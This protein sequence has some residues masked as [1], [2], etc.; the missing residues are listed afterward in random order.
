MCP[1]KGLGTPIAIPFPSPST[2]EREERRE[3]KGD[4][5]GDP[6]E[7]LVCETDTP[8]SQE[9]PLTG[10]EEVITHSHT[11]L[12]SESL[13]SYSTK[14][15][16]GGERGERGGKRRRGGE[17]RGRKRDLTGCPPHACAGRACAT[18]HAPR[19]RLEGKPRRSLGLTDGLNR[20][21]QPGH[22]MKERGVLYL[23]AKSQ[24]RSSLPRR[25]ILS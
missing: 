14:H 6:Q 2:L 13:D 19:F 4:P 9:R 16:E 18:K 21:V 20:I 8:D 17:R 3:R 23:H 10:P 7:G 25:D 11:S 24:G 5:S 12:Y 22:K 1:L 15:G